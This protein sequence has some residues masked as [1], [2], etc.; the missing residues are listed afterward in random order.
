MTRDEE[1]AGK[2]A[3]Y[4]NITQ[5]EKQ[6]D[7]FCEPVSA[8]AASEDQGDDSLFGTKK[9]GEYTLDD[10]NSLPDDERYELIDGVLIKMN[11]PLTVHQDIL[12]FL[13]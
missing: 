7:H 5:H 9:Q 11:S 3:V 2:Q 12:D 10:Y 8:Y 1:K 4:D 13:E 6:Q